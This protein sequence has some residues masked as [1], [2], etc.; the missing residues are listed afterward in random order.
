[1]TKDQFRQWIDYHRER[2]PGYSDKILDRNLSIWYD[3]TFSALDLELCKRASDDMAAGDVE[4]PNGFDVDK[5][6]AL[7]RQHVHWLM[8]RR[9]DQQSEWEEEQR[10]IRK[11]R[12]K[13]ATEEISSSI[14]LA[15]LIEYRK[16]LRSSMMES[17]IAD[18]NQTADF[19]AD[20]AEINRLASIE[21]KRIFD[22]GVPAEQ[23][24]YLRGQIAQSSKGRTGGIF[25]AVP[26]PDSSAWES[27]D[28]QQAAADDRARVATA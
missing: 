15:A 2:F 28:E 5:L 3:I 23:E 17:W 26:K 18:G 24:K 11:Q 4:H 20:E 14:A 8:S 12:W 25:Q 9:R 16:N 6:P 7:V 21:C 22:E 19:Q 1:M 27:Y 13:P 10:R